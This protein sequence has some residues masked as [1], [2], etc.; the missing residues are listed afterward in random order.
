MIEL[1]LTVP[2]ASF[3]L[4]VR[5]KLDARAIAIVGP[6]GSGK[7]TLL[8][9]IAGLRPSARGR[10]VIDGAALMELPPNERRVGWVPQ[11]VALFPHLDVAANIAFG[12]RGPVDDAI[13]VLEL[14][15]LLSR[16]PATL[17]GGERQRVGLARA[18]ATKP[19]VLLLDEPLAAVDVAHRA[20]ILPWLLKVRDASNV[21]M[22]HVTHDLGEATALATHAIVLRE[23]RVAAA[24]TIREAIGAAPELALDNLI[25]GEVTAAGVL[26]I[27]DFT[28]SV[29]RGDAVGAAVYAIGANELIVATEQPRGIS[30]RN[31]L[32]A[33]VT[34]V[35]IAGEDA[36]V[37]LDA[38]GTTLRAK[39]TAA[40]VDELSLAKAARV[41]LIIKTHAL[42][43]VS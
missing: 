8:E 36:I 42:Q 31:V 33:M 16:K 22:L 27:G 18:L 21:P 37:E 1:D 20:R 11:E 15:A 19:R 4:E 28:L 29:P 32:D 12:A 25:F 39:V 3:T 23:G 26:A 35:N 38:L 5:A 30:A 6:S 40:A 9:T 13:D 24:G 14:R 43:R 10:V 7:S 34:R 2:L 17:S 41:F